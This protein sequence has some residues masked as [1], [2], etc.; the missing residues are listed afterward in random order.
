MATRGA[1]GYEKESWKA[2]TSKRPLY[3]KQEKEDS[4][5]KCNNRGEKEKGNNT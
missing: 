3:D 1:G 2:L 4:F 5:Q